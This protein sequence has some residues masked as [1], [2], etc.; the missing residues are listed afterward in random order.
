MKTLSEKQKADHKKRK[1]MGIAKIM[2]P[3][4]YIKE[5][6]AEVHKNPDGSMKRIESIDYQLALKAARAGNGSFVQNTAGEVHARQK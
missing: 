1:A 5:V 4:R 3:L 6:T 2:R